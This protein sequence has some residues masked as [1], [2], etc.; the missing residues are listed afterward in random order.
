MI[1]VHTRDYVGTLRVCIFYLVCVSTCACAQKDQ[2]QVNMQAY[3]KCSQ[4][5][6]MVLQGGCMQCSQKNIDAQVMLRLPPLL[7]FVFHAAYGRAV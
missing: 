2:D 5:A 7:P 3:M 1:Y 6:Q 4:D